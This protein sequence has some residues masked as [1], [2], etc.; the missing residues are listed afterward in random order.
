[1]TRGRGPGLLHLLQ[2]DARTDRAFPPRVGGRVPG[3]QGSW[4]GEA[5]EVRRGI[6]PCDPPAYRGEVRERVPFPG[7]GG[8]SKFFRGGRFGAGRPHSRGGGV[9][10]GTSTSTT[11]RCV[12]S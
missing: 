12:S 5:V 3:G 7:R 1:G 10:T 4:R 2:R 9:W 6:P 11:S 8:D